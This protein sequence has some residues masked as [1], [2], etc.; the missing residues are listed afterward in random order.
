MCSG[1]FRTIVASM[2]TSPGEAAAPPLRT[3]AREPFWNLPNTITVVRMAAVPVILLLPLFPGPSGSRFVAWCFIV[4]ATTDLL[5]GWL[6]RRGQQETRTGKLLDPLVDKLLVTT[7]LVV[8]LA[9]DRIPIW[10]L[11][12]VVVI[13]GRELAV[14]GLRGLASVG[15]H[16]MAARASGKAK[17]LV[18]NIAIGALLFPETTLGLPAHD[19]G[20][21][22][23]AVA[24]ALTL[25]SGWHYF[26]DYFGAPGGEQ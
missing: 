26:A 10:C 13:I 9:V 19:I 4:A 7:S 16:V 3:H 24:T 25:W 23:L 11:P 1:C 22:L 15:G 12:L 18:Q 6:A 2:T 14:T 5:D 17:T 8:L 20:L 21:T